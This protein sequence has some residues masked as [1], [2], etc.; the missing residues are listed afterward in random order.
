M[1]DGSV[2]VSARAASTLAR[3]TGGYVVAASWR[4]LGAARGCPRRGREPGAA[5]VGRRRGAGGRRGL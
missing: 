1:V 3:R 4:L 5:G 2:A